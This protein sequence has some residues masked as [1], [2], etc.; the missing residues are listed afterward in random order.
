VRATVTAIIAFVIAGSVMPIIIGF[1]MRSNS[2]YKLEPIWY[3][4]NPI[5]LF[6]ETKIWVQCFTL[7]STWATIALLLSV[8]HF[9]HQF[10]LF[11]PV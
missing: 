4:G 6:L 5:V 8:P 1:L 7:T 10:K 9:V 2:W 3:I 11:K